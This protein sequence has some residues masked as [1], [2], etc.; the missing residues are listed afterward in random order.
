MQ[1]RFLVK[2]PVRCHELTNSYLLM[3]TDSHTVIPYKL[4]YLV[5]ICLVKFGK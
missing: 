1:L 3:D 5:K 4:N 2:V